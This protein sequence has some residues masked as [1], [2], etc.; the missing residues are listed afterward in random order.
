MWRCNSSGPWR[1]TEAMGTT[2]LP[3]LASTPPSWPAE[4]TALYRERWEPMVRVATMLLGRR[5]EAEE[6]VQEAFAALAPRWSSIEVPAAYLRRMDPALRE[7]LRL[8]DDLAILAPEAFP[9]VVALLLHRGHAPAVVR[10]VM[11]A[12]LMRLAEQVWR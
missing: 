10:K 7:K 1:V 2:P 9:E 11:G 8:D 12:N 4:L 3:D 6:V 5:A